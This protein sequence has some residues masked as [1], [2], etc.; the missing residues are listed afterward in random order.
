MQAAVEVAKSDLNLVL[1]NSESKKANQRTFITDAAGR[2]RN[3][4]ASMA[5]GE[6]AVKSAKANLENAKAKFN[7]VSDL[8]KQGFISAQ[9]VDDSRTQVSVM[10]AILTLLP[11]S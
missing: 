10:E 11:R 1:V 4:E 8:Y 5:N 3:A 9:D 2:V 6:A 7:R